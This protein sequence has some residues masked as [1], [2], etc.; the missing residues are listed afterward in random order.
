MLSEERQRPY[1]L[2]KNCLKACSYIRASL[3]YLL[4]AIRYLSDALK[5]QVIQAVPNSR[6]HESLA[7]QTL[8]SSIQR[9]STLELHLLFVLSA[10]SLSGSPSLVS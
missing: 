5:S 2:Q 10:K 6:E 9:K 8:F 4:V 1:K 3:S 7:P